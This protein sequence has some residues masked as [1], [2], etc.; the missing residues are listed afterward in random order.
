MNGSIVEIAVFN[1][2]A[3]AVS[4]ELLRVSTIGTGTA[5]TVANHEAVA[6]S[7]LL[8]KKDFTST[9]PTKVTGA[10][11]A[12]TLGASV[13]AGMIWTFGDK[14]LTTGLAGTGV[15]ICL[16]PVGTGQACDVYFVWDE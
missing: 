14:G 10:I 8:P 1:T 13:G 16:F 15:G 3:V 11:V 9:A 6:V 4:L 7:T 5:V 2:T 12:T